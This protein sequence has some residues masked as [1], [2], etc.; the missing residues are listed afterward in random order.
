MPVCHP[1][2]GLFEEEDGADTESSL[3]LLR[4]HS[5]L[6]DTALLLHSQTL[7]IEP[8]EDRGRG[9]GR[10]DR[11]KEDGGKGGERRKGKERRGGKERAEERGREEG[12]R[13]GAEMNG[14]DKRKGRDKRKR[15]CGENVQHN[16][17]LEMLN[18]H[19]STQ[20]PLIF[21]CS[22]YFGKSLFQ[23]EG[24]RAMAWAVC[25]ELEGPPCL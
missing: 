14:S 7:E 21:K 19:I 11:R 18:R 3:H 12:G 9:G 23:E 25:A 22:P 2:D 16:N 6:T 24:S 8:E 10:G 13:K 17:K 20:I 5:L 15:W 4:T 1:L